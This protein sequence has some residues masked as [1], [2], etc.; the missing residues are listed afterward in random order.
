[1][2]TRHGT[3]ARNI[4]EPVLSLLLSCPEADVGDLGEFSPSVPLSMLQV[5][6]G[7][8]SIE[9]VRRYAHRRLTIHGTSTAN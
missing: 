4:N 9:M 6:G 5:M 8:E 7:W 3:P 1:M 2:T